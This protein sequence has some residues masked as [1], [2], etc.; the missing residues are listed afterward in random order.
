MRE[1]IH[2]HRIHSNPGCGKGTVLA[3]PEEEHN[4]RVFSQHSPLTKCAIHE[5]GQLSQSTVPLSN[6][7][8]LKSIKF[9]AGKRSM[10]K[11]MSRAVVAHA[12]VRL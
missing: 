11:D 8:L 2:F 3:P 12:F 1:E 7:G 9:L 5:Q 6:D 4:T 10:K